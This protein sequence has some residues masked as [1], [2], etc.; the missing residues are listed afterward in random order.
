M[1]TSTEEEALHH[2][3]HIAET[4]Q[5]NN[6]SIT[7]EEIQKCLDKFDTLNNTQTPVNS[8]IIKDTINTLQSMQNLIEKTDMNIDN[9]TV[10]DLYVEYRTEVND[11]TS[12]L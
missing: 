4:V 2:L 7:S 11:I 8:A 10:N 5:N 6:E 12:E 3:D 1:T 9:G